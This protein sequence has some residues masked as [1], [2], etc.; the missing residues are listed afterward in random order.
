M[1]NIKDHENLKAWPFVEAKKIVKNLG[2]INN[3]NWV[4]TLRLTSYR[5]I[6]RSC[7]DLNGSECLREFS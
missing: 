5:N 6:W 7:K 2:G 1:I 3:F 4:W